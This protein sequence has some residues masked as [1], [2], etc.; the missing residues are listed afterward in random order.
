[1][2]IDDPLQNAKLRCVQFQKH[3][4]LNISLELQYLTMTVLNAQ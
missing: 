2:K 1:M 4:F 3:F